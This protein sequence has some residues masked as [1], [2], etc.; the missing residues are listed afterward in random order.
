MLALWKEK[1]MEKGNITV[2]IQIVEKYFPRP[3]VIKYY[4]CPSCQT[5]IDIPSQRIPDR[6]TPIKK[7]FS[8]AKKE[9]AKSE[10]TLNQ[11][12]FQ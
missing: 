11:H 12:S 8:P 7:P 4:V 2:L 10:L 6:A 3:K 9:E 5:L 1:K